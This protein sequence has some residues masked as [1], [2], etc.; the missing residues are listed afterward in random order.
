MG[1]AMWSQE[2]RGTWSEPMSKLPH[3]ALLV[4]GRLVDGGFLRPEGAAVENQQSNNRRRV[5]TQDNVG[6]EGG[7]GRAM[8]AVRAVRAVRAIWAVR[9]VR[10]MW[11]VWVRTGTGERSARAPSSHTRRRT[12]K[13]VGD[14]TGKREGA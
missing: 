8:W 10:A 12:Y 4:L 11:A 5:C 13:S 1:E 9:A 2:I 7:A 14:T 6:G 3:L